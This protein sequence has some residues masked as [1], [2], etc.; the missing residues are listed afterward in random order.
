MGA[1]AA[2]AALLVPA[3]AASAQPEGRGWEQV[4]PVKK[5]GY[6][7]PA[8]GAGAQENNIGS[9]DGTEFVFLSS[10]GYADALS[11]LVTY[12]R[13]VR[14][15]D[16][17]RTNA[18]NPPMPS[19]T[20]LS[21]GVSPLVESYS[22][23]LSKMIFSQGDTPGLADGAPD[24]FLAANF[25]RDMNDGTF[26]WLTPPA[27]PSPLPP[28]TVF[29]VGASANM[30]RIYVQANP[31]D[32]QAGNESVRIL[33]Q[34]AD[35]VAG[36]ALYEIVGGVVTP[37][38]TL[39]DGT[40]PVDGAASLAGSDPIPQ[41][42]ISTPVW[43]VNRYA[44][45]V[46][47]NGTRLIFESPDPAIS[48]GDTP[49]YMHIDGQPSILISRSEL[50]GQPSAARGSYVSSDGSKVWLTSQSQLTSDAPADTT[51][52]TYEFDVATQDL[53]YSQDG[54]A[55]VSSADGSR[56][57]Y[58][59]GTTNDLW[60]N[61]SGVTSQIA[62]NVP[63]GFS[64]NKHFRALA[65]GSKFLFTSDTAIPGFND[66]GGFD[67]LF[68]YDVASRQLS[69]ASCPQT[70]DPAGPVGEGRNEAES[71][72]S[73]APR[74][75]GRDG[76]VFFDT[77]TSLVPEDDNTVRDVYE[78]RDG[79]VRLL[80]GGRGSS[81]TNYLDNSVDG[82]NVF[83]TTRD[84]LVRQDADDNYDVYDARVGGGFPD[85]PP[86]PQCDVDCQGP[87][88]PS[89]FFSV[90]GSAVVDAEGNL[91]DTT[92]LVRPSPKPSFTVATVSAKSQKAFAKS[93]K[94]TV[95]VR[96]NTAAKITAS[97]SVR[98][99][100]GWTTSPTASKALK[101]AGTVKLTVRLSSKARRYLEQHSSLR[102]RV[103]V[104]DSRVGTKR[105]SMVLRAGRRPRSAHAHRGAAKT[106]AVTTHA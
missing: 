50:T 101:G 30:D 26:A 67:Q 25:I 16:G 68:V 56:F 40:V 64:G 76:S 95:S 20:L 87:I 63:M 34:D 4:S 39:P 19:G 85:P 69:C 106:G 75:F 66:A 33:A 74:I 89:P 60:V 35:R 18:A 7:A 72:G 3:A 105:A 73:Q 80:S 77:A 97:L 55:I 84:R 15:S 49:L 32:R 28:R 62:V 93:G 81:D 27:V 11:S 70:G 37:A 14:T 46:S 24:G 88:T 78:W 100:G 98:A 45:R 31:A 10:G 82:N 29:S 94:L 103:N 83:F 59:A 36:A 22:A 12:Y 96:S 61:D 6:D 21:P 92:T 52:K 102:V 57:L 38:D 86:P 13:A 99:G 42:G 48:G 79:Q 1:A 43:T 44:N 90:P 47:A 65:D 51:D 91:P 58:F 9:P 54:P 23:D 104:S 8:V 71:G 41:A 5:N 17:W 2:A 53:T